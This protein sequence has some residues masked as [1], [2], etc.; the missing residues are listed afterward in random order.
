MPRGWFP[1][2]FSCLHAKHAEPALQEWTSWKQWALS[3]D[4]WPT[5]R[6]EWIAEYRRRQEELR[7]E[8]KRYTNSRL[9]GTEYF[10]LGGPPFLG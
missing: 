2:A 3:H 9:P 4:D 10:K 7:L 6:D 1:G 8:R 5:F